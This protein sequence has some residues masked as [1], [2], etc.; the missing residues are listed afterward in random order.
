MKKFKKLLKTAF[1]LMVSTATLISCSED[2][3]IPIVIPTNSIVDFVSSNS[4]Y[5]ILLE[6][7]QTADGGI[8]ETLNS[9]GP[10]T[11]FAPNNAAFRAF[12]SANNFDYLSD[13]PTAMLSQILLNHVVGGNALAASLSTGYDIKSFSTATPSGANMSLY[14]NTADGVVINGVSTV[15]TADISL[16]NGTVHAVD[17]IIALPTVVTF[18]AAD[19]NFSILKTALTRTDLTFDFVGTL[20]T[21][22]GTDPAP[23]TVFAPIDQAFVDLLE[24]LG[25]SSLDDID[26]PTLNATLKMHAV[27][28]A[29]VSA[30]ELSDDMVISTL[31]GDITANTTD[32][33][34]LTDSNERVSNI[35][36]VNVQA[37]NGV[38]HAIDKVLL[39]T[40]PEP[41]NTI[42]DFVSN[43]DDYSILLEA[44]QIADGDLD[45]VLSGDGPFTVFAPN[46]AAFTA[47]LS[48]NNFNALSDIPTDI[49]SQVLLNHVVSG[50]AV[51]SSLSTGYDVSSLSTATPDGNN[52]SLYINTADGVVINGVSTVTTA[53]VSVD[54]GTIHAV[55][56]VIGLPT[57]VTFAVADPNFSILKTALTRADLTFDFV[58]TLSTANG[59]D[60]APF[61]VF[62]PI[63][64]AFVDLLEELEKDSLDDIDEETLNAT[65]KMHAVAGANVLAAGLSDGLTISTL[66]GDITANLTGGATLTDANNRVSQIVAVDVQASNGVIHA[67]DKVLLKEE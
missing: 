13:V 16:D 67:I 59:T 63:D 39:A 27:A 41:T 6:A 9:G 52:M 28:G 35:I 44:L 49:L 14:I 4:D 48:D 36:A 29:N 56:T 38:I 5:S 61:T 55:N 51:S 32:G 17:A 2:D 20:S 45:V 23:F 33:P 30:S 53:D 42:V 25:A 3:K 15:T 40:M 62:A 18:A 7:L 8:V 43:N 1:I 24:D 50:N 22:N 37:S 57:V 34:T 31:G 12:L 65:L 54:N 46:N 58:G 66:G 11:V 21:A 64:Q 19:P 47:F 60:P 10:F 26:E